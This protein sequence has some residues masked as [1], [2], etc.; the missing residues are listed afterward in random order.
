MTDHQPVA[1]VLAPMCTPFRAD[2]EPDSERFVEHARWL[3][4]DG[5]TGLVPF[6]TTSEALSLGLQERQDLLAALVEGGVDPGTLLPGTGLCSIP[7]TVILT[8]QAVELGC[9][10]V[11]ML[12][13]F[14][15]K[16]QSDAGL[17]AHFAEVIDRIG[18][19]RLK[20][21]L[22]HIPPQAQVGFSLE[23]IGKLRGDFP[24]T[25]VGIKDSSGDWNNT[26]ALLSEFPG[27]GTFVGSEPFLL[28][29][30]TRGGAGTITALAN[31]NAARIRRLYEEWES[32]DARRLQ[33]EITAMRQT[34]QR[35]VMIP[36]LKQIIG[37]YRDDPG[38]G[39]VRPP[40]PQLEAADAKPFI[41]QL[42]Q[43]FDFSLRF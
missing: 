36:L 24:N 6:G 1:G 34:L 5:C 38:W 2:L 18:D 15:F 29:A 8:R 43:G 27:F 35:N 28:D 9:A 21:Y 39:P 33:D 42:E 23:L 20:I 10:G 40:L 14:Y 11:L 22:Y 16:G 12:P 31:I 26:Q 13:P 32:A 4:E 19:E 17:Y 3:L 25:V 30:L 41:E 37:H 7:D